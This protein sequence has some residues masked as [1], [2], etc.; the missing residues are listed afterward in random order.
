MLQVVE[1][2]S[3]QKNKN[4]RFLRVHQNLH[5]WGFVQRVGVRVVFLVGRKIYGWEI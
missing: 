3:I 1:Q 5:S 4:A 2:F